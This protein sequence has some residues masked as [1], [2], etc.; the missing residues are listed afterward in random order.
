MAESLPK[1]GDF[2][3]QVACAEALIRVIKKSDRADFG[4]KCFTDD[5]VFESF[6]KIQDA[7]F[8]V[9]SY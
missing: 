4:R 3:M 5:A 1:T 7:C 8:E 9:V 6:L 2:E